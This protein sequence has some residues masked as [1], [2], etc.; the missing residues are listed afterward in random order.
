MSIYGQFCPIA[1][2]AEVLGERWTLLLIRELLLGSTRFS[3]LQRGLAKMSPSLLTKRLKELEAAQLISK[4]KI[5]GQKGYEYYL[6]KAGLDLEPLVMEMAKWGMKWVSD[7]L[8]DAE[9]DA[10]LLMWDICRNIKT[11]RLPASRAVVKLFLTDATSLKDWWI[12]IHGDD[13]DLCTEN[14]GHE[15]DIYVTSSSRTLT[16]IW[17]GDRTWKCVDE[18]GDIKLIGSRPLIN[19]IHEWLGYSSTAALNPRASLIN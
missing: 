17:L 18:E 10:E 7:S 11:D 13:T 9:L 6:T 1:K 16:Q 5:T 3:E 8:S 14:P 15:P 2:S 4:T 12:V 19:T